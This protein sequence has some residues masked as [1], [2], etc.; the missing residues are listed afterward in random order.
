MVGERIGQQVEFTVL[1]A[2]AERAVTVV[3]DE[4]V[5]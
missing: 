1:R 2:G 5:G 4:L 3:P